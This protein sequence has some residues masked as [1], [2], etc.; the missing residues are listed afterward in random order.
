ME[1][2]K[3]VDSSTPPSDGPMV[4]STE[5]SSVD[6]STSDA[7][8]TLLIKDC[9]P[10]ETRANEIVLDGLGEAFDTIGSGSV[11]DIDLSQYETVIVPST[12]TATYYDR[13]A[14]ESTTFDSFVSEGGTL[15][16]HVTDRGWPCSTQAAMS[17]LPRGV[18]K[19]NT[20]E[21]YLDRV[22]SDHPVL[23]GL[24]DNALDNWNSSTHGYLTDLPDDATVAVGINGDR[25]RA[26]YAEYEHGSGKVLATMQ[27]LEWPWNRGYGT[28][29]VL[30]NELEYAISGGESDPVSASVAT[31]QFIPGENENITEG[32]HPLNSGLM[33]VF[34]GAAD[35]PVHTLENLD[36]PET[37]LPYG[38]VLDSW[39]YGDMRDEIAADFDEATR[40][41]AGK[42][43]DARGEESHENY[44]HIN[45]VDVTFDQV[46]G[47]IDQSSVEIEFNEAG[48]QPDDERISLK[49]ED[50]PWSVMVD[51]DVNGIP[52]DDWFGEEMRRANQEPRFYSYDTDYEYDGVEGVRVLTISGGYV[53]FGEQLANKSVEDP[54]G[55]FS[56]IWDWDVSD[57]LAKA[58]TFVDPA[59]SPIMDWLA[60]VPRTWSFIEFVVL[61]DGRRYGRVWDASQYPSLFTYMDGERQHMDKMP[62][63]PAEK[64]NGW[65]IAFFSRA[66]AGLTPY[67]GAVEKYKH[68][69]KNPERLRSEA[70]TEFQATIDKLPVQFNASKYL[71][72]MPRA[73]VG[74]ESEAGNEVDDPT[75]PFDSKVS[76]IPSNIIEPE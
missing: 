31:V 50:N 16:A 5:S 4:A 53:G 44:R 51:H 62:Y 32:G 70:E 47:T 58:A 9:H 17:F 6:Y 74:L 42:Y 61:A 37:L 73:T 56:A 76:L 68:T 43:Q 49:G 57:A 39:Y 45:R 41:K 52:Y 48:V 33:H 69:A 13:L 11:N 15:V 36:D 29:E 7:A 20:T 66:M 3:S 40:A 10:W 64:F 12:Q 71:P 23:D 54:V 21:D 22:A 34:D 72:I 2:S 65:L 30:R 63:K 14:A 1:M 27:T 28:K 59:I 38:P 19:R 24:S 26:T 46:D 75:E 8:S 67:Q 25:S 18:G 35:L 55:F 60:V